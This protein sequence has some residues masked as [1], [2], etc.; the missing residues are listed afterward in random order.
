MASDGLQPEQPIPPAR[1]RSSEEERRIARV[2]FN[3]PMV[4]LKA[5]HWVSRHPG[6]HGAVREACDLIL[7]AQ[8]KD[9]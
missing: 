6:G 8:G 9:G 1:V 7:A 4:A 3:R 5:A 2:T